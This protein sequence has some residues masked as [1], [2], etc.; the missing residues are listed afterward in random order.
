MISLYS[1]SLGPKVNEVFEIFLLKIFNF[2]KF[3]AWQ[4]LSLKKIF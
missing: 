3:L 4:V 1:E 2:G